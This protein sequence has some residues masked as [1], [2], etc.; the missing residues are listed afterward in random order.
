VGENRAELLILL[1]EAEQ[2]YLQANWLPKECQIVSAFTDKQP[3]LRCH[4]TSRNESSHRPLKEWLDPKHTL[5]RAVH[6]LMQNIQAIVRRIAEEEN[7][8]RVGIPMVIDRHEFSQLS[9]RVTR[10]AIILIIP[11]WLAAKQLAS[12]GRSFTSLHSTIEA[13]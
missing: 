11:E 9:M 8:S 1:D 2:E 13:N 3:N 4:G 12:S 5:D 7:Q 10:Y 6:F